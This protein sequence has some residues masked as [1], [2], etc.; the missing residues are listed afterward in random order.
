M[1]VDFHTCESDLC[2][3]FDIQ[4]TRLTRSTLRF[5]FDVEVRHGSK[6]LTNRRV[7]TMSDA[8]APDGIK[9]DM[10][11][12]VYSGCGDGVHVWSPGGVLIGKVVVPGGI[13]NFCFG[14]SGELFLLNETRFWV[15]KI[16]KHVKGALL[17]G[18]GLDV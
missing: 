9:C 6:F 10:A 4:M 14:K 16:A 3:T 1:T 8:G 17:A 15:V 5:A 7:F 2:A 12:N 13:A 18:M 11:G